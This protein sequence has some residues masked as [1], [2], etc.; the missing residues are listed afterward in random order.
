[1]PSAPAENTPTSNGLSAAKRISVRRMSND[2]T[3]SP[4]ASTAPLA[5]SSAARNA[6]DGIASE[7]TIPRNKYSREGRAPARPPS[8]GTI[9]CRIPPNSFPVGSLPTPTFA[10]NAPAKRRSSAAERIV[11]TASIV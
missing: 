2:L 8:F 6:P 9:R 11:W 7:L 10:A 4:F 1:M 5:A 3:S